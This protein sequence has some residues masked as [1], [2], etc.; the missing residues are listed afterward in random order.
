MLQVSSS[1]TPFRGDYG[2][3]NILADSRCRLM[4]PQSATSNYGL[5]ASSAY[6]QNPSMSPLAP[7]TYR[8]NSVSAYQYP[9]KQCYS[10]AY[11]NGMEYPDEGLEYGLQNS[12]Y[13]LGGQ[14]QLGLASSYATPNRAWTPA[15]HS[16]STAGVYL[17][18][19]SHSS[20]GQAH[21]PYSNGQSYALRPAIPSE[22]TNFS[23][24]NLASALPVSSPIAD[25]ILPTPNVGRQLPMAT[26]T[27][28]ADGFPSTT[29]NN[30]H[31]YLSTT[32]P[33][34]AGLSKAAEPMSESAQLAYLPLSSPA[35]QLASSFSS[36]GPP[37]MTS[38]QQ[39]P[40]YAPLHDNFSVS[41][42]GTDSSLS[43]QDEQGEMYSYERGDPHGSRN[44][45]SGRLSSGPAYVP[46]ES[47][48]SYLSRRS[49]QDLPAAVP[50]HRS[51][52]SSLRAT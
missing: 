22:H 49:S 4:M 19:E 31:G 50:Q 24:S 5:Q 1:E 52:V 9:G 16:K 38:Q 26:Y 20:Y 46:H 47:S 2:F 36:T 43:S 14:D 34:S 45:V 39:V 11:N 40:S 25:R 41:N 35:D 17:D 3:D 7:A 23:L 33:V 18:S 42:L 32:A 44:S 21:M 37:P 12:T 10:I 15:H 13:T 48:S 51:S 8:A 27:R 30:M 6:P 29:T 28:S